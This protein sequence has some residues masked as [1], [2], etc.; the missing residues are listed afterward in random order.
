MRGEVRYASRKHVLERGLLPYVADPTQDW[1]TIRA[2]EEAMRAKAQVRF[3]GLG[4][5]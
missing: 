5:E 3:K 2:I 4:L 1:Y